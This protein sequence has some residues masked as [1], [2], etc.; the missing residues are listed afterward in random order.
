MILQLFWAATL[1]KSGKQALQKL[2]QLYKILKHH[3]INIDKSMNNL[4]CKDNTKNNE[5]IF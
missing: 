3:N 5:L 4:I 1:P 2:L